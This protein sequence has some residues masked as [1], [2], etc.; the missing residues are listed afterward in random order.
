MTGRVDLIDGAVESHNSPSGLLIKRTSALLAA[1][2]F[3]LIILLSVFRGFDKD[4]FEAI[5]SSWKIY[6]GERIYI[7]FFQHHNPF[8]YYLILPVFML[9]KEGTGVIIVSRLLMLPFLSGIAGCVFFLANRLYDRVT[10]WTAVFILFS[11]PAF[12]LSAIEVRPDVPQVLFGLCGI[13][14]LFVFYDSRKLICLIGSGFLLGL[15][16]MFLQKAMWLIIPLVPVILIRLYRKELKLSE[17]LFFSASFIMLPAIYGF[18]LWRSGG[19]DKYFFLNFT[20]NAIGDY[21]TGLNLKL[22]YSNLINFNLIFAWSFISGLSLKRQNRLQGEAVWITFFTAIMALCSRVY[23][24]QYFLP[25]LV[26]TAVICAHGFI[27]IAGSRLVICLLAMGISAV[28]PASVYSRHIQEGNRKQ[29]EQVELVREATSPQD[30]VYDGDAQFNLFRKDLDYFWYSVTPG[31]CL[32]KY[33]KLRPY[34]YDIYNLIEQYRPLIISATGIESPDD[35]RITEN[36]TAIEGFKGLY[37]RK[38]E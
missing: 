28:V 3:I 36:Y 32:D 35:P 37:I 31:K 22:L 12:S 7:D 23:F 38:T 18:T 33:K 25:F 4:E 29:L 8:F 26:F 17:V 20:F 21:Q 6:S 5:K 34:S 19:W 24:P 13:C 2:L 9:L 11:I 10:A 27:E 15:S 30:Y 16:F 14:L 1:A